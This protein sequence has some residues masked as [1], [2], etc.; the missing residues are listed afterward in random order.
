MSTPTSRSCQSCGATISGD[1]PCSACS[2]EGVLAFGN[3]GLDSSEEPPG[4]SPFELPS[5]FGHYRV[6]REIAA[7]GAGMVYEAVDTVINRPVALKM[8]RQVLFSTERERVRFQSEA[9]LVSQMDHPHIIPIYDVGNIEGQPYFTMKLIREGNLAQRLDAGKLPP[10]EAAVLVAKIAHAVHHAHQ[11]GVLHRDLKPSNILLDGDGQPL[12]TDFGLAKWLDRDSGLTVTQ[13]ISGTPD[14]MSP[15]QAAG[16]KGAISTATDVWALGVML[17][18]MLTGCLPFRGENHAEIFRHIAEREPAAPSNLTPV[19][20]DLETLCLRCLQKDPDKRLSSAHELAQELGRWL[21]GEPI[22]SRR[23]TRRERLIK[24]TRR[25]PYRTT[26]IIAMSAILTAAAVAITWQWRSAEANALAQRETASTAMLGQALRAREHHDFGQ[27]RRLLDRIDPSLRGFDWRLLHALCRGDELSRY[28]LGDDRG[29]EPQSIALLPGSGHLAILSA[30]GRLHLRDQAGNEVKSPRALPPSPEG[31]GEAKRYRGLTFSP[32]GQRFAYANGDSLTVIDANKMTILREE[33]SR[34]PQF[35]WLDDDRLLYGFNG[36]VAAP[37]YPDAGAWI[38]N[39][40][41][42]TRTPIPEMCAPLAVSPDRRHFALHRVDTHHA[43]WT[44]TLHVFQAGQ[45]LHKPAKAIYTLPGQEYPGKLAFSHTGKFLALSSG[46]QIYKSAR[47]I[48]LASGHVVFDHEFRFPLHGLAFDPEERRLGLVGDDGAVRLYNI[49]RGTP[50]GTNA[51]TYDDDAANRHRQ[52]IDGRGAHSPPRDLITRTA[53]DG[54]AQFFL[55][56]ESRVFSLLYDSAGLLVTAGGD[57]TIRQWPRDVAQS[58]LRISHMATSYQRSHP[59]VSIDGRQ[60]LFNIDRGAYLGD[61]SGTTTA[62]QNQ[63]APLAVLED[64]RLLTQDRDST[65]VVVWVS[66]QNGVREQRRLPSKCT[67]PTHWGQTRSGSLS[68]DETRLAGSMDGWLFTVDLE[69]GTVKWSGDL[70]KSASA[71]ASQAISPDGQWVASSDFG[72]RVSIHRVDEPAE[73]FCHLVGQTRDYDTAIAFARDGRLLYTGN[74]DGRVR[75]WDTASWKEIPTLG[76]PAHRGAVT[77]LALSHDGSFIA[78]SG[79]DTLK[80][81]PIEPGPGDQHRREHLSF[82]LDQ[83]ANWIRFARGEHGQDRALLHTSPGQ[84]L[85]IWETDQREQESEQQIATPGLLPRPLAHH[86]VIRLLDGE[87]LIAGGE[88]LTGNSE[89]AA[90][91]DC[92]LYDPATDT[93]RV[94]GSMRQPR[95]RFGSLTLLQDGT[96]LAVGGPVREQN[97]SGNCEV[98]NPRSGTWRETGSMIIPRVDSARV[99]LLSGKVL[100]VGGRDADLNPLASCELYDPVTDTWSLTGSLGTARFGA[101]CALLPDGT[102]LCIGG[103]DT[104]EVLSSCEIYD[105]QSGTWQATASI[106]EARAYAGAITLATGQVLLVGGQLPSGYLSSCELYDPTAHTWRV[107]GA[108]P[109]GPQVT[110]AVIL[111]PSGKVFFSG[112]FSHGPT[113]VY[114]FDP[115][116]D[117]WTAGPA[118]RHPAE[119][120]TTT[121]LDS[122]KILITGGNTPMSAR[123]GVEVIDPEQPLR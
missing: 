6:E 3:D 49:T 32:S 8:L 120:R 33:V 110:Q 75:V 114:L 1:L 122:G 38:L 59:A 17:Y 20:P 68:Q 62:L 65:D 60:V 52:H 9:E 27:A 56:H 46:V 40:R 58:A 24:W 90:L 100:A 82:H 84:R 66:D 15:E 39:L 109:Q 79:D 71:F 69:S 73:V 43:E 118:L 121:L 57:G 103:Q 119:A 81:F 78:T 36:S 123:G 74:E 35:G 7:G 29:S 31:E 5:S 85:E 23:I 89:L 117:T 72:P 91:S 94:T 53:Q 44:R 45:N 105:P 11:R 50:L 92:Y 83:P 88:G 112:G 97:F 61:A 106:A 87:V 107:T 86:G 111:L 25:H 101:P 2:L 64:G 37:P 93:W 96:V 98:Y 77:A 14:Y 22:Q 104:Q 10:R 42:D 116:N 108:L 19:D 34:L 18:Q 48:E 30:D 21:E 67:H 63:H 115:E 4:F 41:T 51:N 102:I 28:R 76:W 47:A 95:T 70:G 99:R 54:R 55:G 80:L 26:A 12:L 16:D 13:T 113:A